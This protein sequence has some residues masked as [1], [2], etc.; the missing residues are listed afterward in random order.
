LPLAQF[1]YNDK[2][3]QSTG[4]SPFYLNY[5]QHP[6]KGV[7]P[8]VQVKNAAAKDFVEEMKEIREDAESALKNAAETMKQFYDRKRKPS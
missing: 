2:I 1:S 5:G 8:R 3:H 6:Y 7:E 4:Y